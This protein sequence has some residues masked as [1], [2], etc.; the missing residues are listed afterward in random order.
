MVKLV[1][2]RVCVTWY[3]WTYHWHIVTDLLYA[4]NE[5]LHALE[6]GIDVA[7]RVHHHYIVPQCLISRVVDVGEEDVGRAAKDQQC[8]V[9]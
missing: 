7:L 3:W 4:F 8:D 1:R 9:E 2:C 5:A 6:D